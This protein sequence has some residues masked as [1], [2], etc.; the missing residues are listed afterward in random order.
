MAG[1][2]L[3]QWAFIILTYKQITPSMAGGYLAAML[4]G[5]MMPNV[6]D[7]LRRELSLSSIPMVDK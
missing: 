6:D 1:F 3:T 7:R 4:D 2:S 5:A